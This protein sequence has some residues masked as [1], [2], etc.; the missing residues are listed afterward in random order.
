MVEKYSI[1]TDLALEEKERFEEEN[2]EVQGVVLEEEYDEEREIRTT[3]VKIKT[4][5]GAKTM[6]KPVGTYITM[7][8]PNLA[9]PDE[10]YHREVSVKIAECVE[11]LL[12]GKWKKR[13]KDEDISILMV[14]LG[15]REVTPDALGPYV[16]DNLN[17]TRHI[18]R[19]YGKY[20]MG[21]DEVTLVSALVP[22]VMAQTGMET[23]EI[24]RGVVAETKPDVILVVDALAARNSRRLDRTI[25]IADTGISPGSGVGNHRNA[26]TEDSI[27]IP[28]IAI[29][30]PTVVDAATI[31]NDAMENLMK[32]MEHSEALKG[33]GVVLQGYHAA[34]KYEL[35]RQLISPHLNGM[36]VTPKDIDDTVKRISFTISEGLNLLFSRNE[37]RGEMTGQA[38]NHEEKGI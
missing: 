37:E 24:V 25:Q 3:T 19:E 33:V 2:V 35:V 9:V 36:F 11:K 12:K 16:A 18:V 15:N 28:V 13:S 32:E 38:H 1:R 6:G 17:I 10:G 31:V 14:G 8:A 30:V 22:G 27:G 29:G 34:E 5:N 21:E 7:E 26:I 23:A 20:A 4:E